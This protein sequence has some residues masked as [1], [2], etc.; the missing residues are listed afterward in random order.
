MIMSEDWCAHLCEYYDVTPEEALVLGTRASGRKPSLPGSSTCKPVSGKTFED[1]WNE[2]DRTTLEGKYRFY[3]D[4]GAWSVF[5]QA[6]RHIDMARM[7]MEMLKA[8]VRFTGPANDEYHLCEYGCGIAPFTHTLLT[9]ARFGIKTRISLVDVPSEHFR[10]GVWR[11]RRDVADDPESCKHVIIDKVAVLP[12]MLPTFASPIDAAIV[13][14]VM[15]HIHNPI[16]ML[17]NLLR[18]MKPN[19]YI[20]ENFIKHDINHVPGPSDMQ[21]ARDQREQF[22]SLLDARAIVVSG[23]IEKA[24]PNGTRIWRLK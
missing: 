14:E 23:E 11:S 16:E 3:E 17:E 15:E 9:S 13:F 1:I 10:F 20:C 6:V 2:G 22:Y 5:R 4:L 19:G 24:N 21:S 7:R 18:H 12:D 8:I